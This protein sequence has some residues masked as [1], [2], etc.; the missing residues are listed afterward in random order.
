[1]LASFHNIKEMIL[2]N[3]EKRERS[4][5]GKEYYTF[6]LEIIDD[7]NNSTILTFFSNDKDGLN[8]KRFK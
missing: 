4:T 5:N 3:V 7:K 1:M 8:F 2:E 6:S